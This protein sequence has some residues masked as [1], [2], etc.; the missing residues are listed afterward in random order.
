[1]A[2]YAKYNQN[3]SDCWWQAK[4]REVIVTPAVCSQN[5]HT[6]WC[7][8]AASYSKW[9][10]LFHAI[11]SVSTEDIIYIF[12][13]SMLNAAYFTCQPPCEFLLNHIIPVPKKGDLSQYI[14]YRGVSLMSCTAKLF[15][16]IFL[17]RI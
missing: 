16:H 17:N 15:N 9:R 1:M 4:N 6:G 8:N 11:F 5:L 2:M 7:R 12:L 13:L 14:S 3:L 10:H